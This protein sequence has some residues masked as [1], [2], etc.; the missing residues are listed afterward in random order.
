MLPTLIAVVDADPAICD[1]IAD[2]LTYSGYPVVCYTDEDSFFDELD[3]VRPTLLI[4]NIQLE[5]RTSGWEV[6]QKLRSCPA[7]NG[8]AVI[9]STTFTHFCQPHRAQIQTLGAR[10]LDKPFELDA[11][12]DTVTQ[13]LR[14]ERVVGA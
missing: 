8:I 14:G 12:L 10:V 2:V 1:M 3:Q 11:L 7:T 9:L 13:A 6:L 4:L 5:R